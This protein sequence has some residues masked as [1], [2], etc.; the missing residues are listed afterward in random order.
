[1]KEKK[2]HFRFSQFLLG[3]NVTD[4]TLGKIVTF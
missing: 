2:N 3:N 1:M 4:V